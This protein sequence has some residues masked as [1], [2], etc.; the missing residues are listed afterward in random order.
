MGFGCG[1]PSH[2]SGCSEAG[3]ARSRIVDGAHRCKRSVTS[4]APTDATS[5]KRLPTPVPTRLR[6]TNASVPTRRSGIDHATA[7]RV[8]FQGLS[9]RRRSG[10]GD[11]EC[12][13][14]NESI[15]KICFAGH[16]PRSEQRRGSPRLSRGFAV[17]SPTRNR[18]AM[19]WRRGCGVK[20][21]S[22][23][24]EPRPVRER[25]V[26]PNARGPVVDCTRFP[27]LRPGS[28]FYASRGGGFDHGRRQR[29]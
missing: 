6:A 23:A 24:Y 2:E 27:T 14:P 12:R 3:G 1:E 17:S 11:C 21:P 28:R 13:Q 22:Q 10:D 20:L 25:T 18:V 15:G 8:R 29:F 5:G 7:A 19:D 16:C 4:S 26:A 9:V